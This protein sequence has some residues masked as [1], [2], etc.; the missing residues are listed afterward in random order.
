MKKGIYVASL[1]GRKLS[2]RYVP[3]LLFSFPFLIALISL[4]PTEAGLKSNRDIALDEPGVGGIGLVTVNPEQTLNSHNVSDADEAYKDKLLGAEPEE[5]DSQKKDSEEKI[6]EKAEPSKIKYTLRKG[7]T[8]AMVAKRYKVSKEEIAGSSGIR[9]IDEVYPGT[10]LYIPTKKGFFYSVKK[11]ERLAYILDRHRVTLEKFLKDNPEIHPDVLEKGSEIFL[12]GAKPR[13][14]IRNYWLIPVYSR[15]ITSPYGPRSWPRRAFHKGIDL[16]ARYVSVRASRSGK[17]TFAGWL[18]G[19]GNAI[20]IKH[21]ND[22]KTLYAHLSKIY[23]K[24]GAKVSRGAVIG[25]SGNTGYSFGAHLH[26]EIARK[27]KPINPAKVLRGL[28]YRRR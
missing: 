25:R 4:I 8:L 10:V 6:A 24:K 15:I 17:V 28:R 5:S 11:G 14:I 12:P 16:K 26:F 19:Y 3:H 18:G 1:F 13:N 23:T 20:V 7:E 27:G 22:Y 9:I 21:A 2:L